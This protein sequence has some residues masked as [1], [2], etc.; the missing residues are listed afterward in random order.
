MVS[1]GLPWLIYPHFAQCT[2]GLSK[3]GGGG[4]PLLVPVPSQSIMGPPFHWSLPSHGTLWFLYKNHRPISC[5]HTHR[6]SDYSFG[7]MGLV[8]LT[9]LLAWLRCFLVC[10]HVL[11]QLVGIII[12]WRRQ[13]LS[14]SSVWWVFYFFFM[15]TVQSLVNDSV[16]PAGRQHSQPCC[17]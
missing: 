1:C 12:F 5:F 9:W 10:L 7:L 15:R 17:C 13:P 6:W 4:S 11:L 2:H 16:S 14:W 3:E 8:D